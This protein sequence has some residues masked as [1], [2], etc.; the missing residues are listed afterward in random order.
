[1]SMTWWEGCKVQNY[2]IQLP[3]TVGFWVACPWNVLKCALI[4]IFINCLCQHPLR[5]PWLQELRNRFGLIF[6]RLCADQFVCVRAALCLWMLVCLCIVAFWVL[7]LSPQKKAFWQMHTNDQHSM[8]KFVLV[9]QGRGSKTQELTSPSGSEATQSAC[10]PDGTPILTGK[11]WCS[12]SSQPHETPPAPF[13]FSS[14]TKFH[15][16]SH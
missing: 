12:A 9:E 6:L 8:G 2:H 14:R 15:S 13:L 1:M 10:G 7:V 3:R 5:W 16:V 11:H 4:C